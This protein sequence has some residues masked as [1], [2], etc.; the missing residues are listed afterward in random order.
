ML[1]LPDWSTSPLSGWAAAAVA[2]AGHLYRF[3]KGAP[4]MPNVDTILADVDAVLTF[5]V[6]R[7]PGT[8]ADEKKAA[9]N[10]LINPRLTAVLTQEGASPF[11]TGLVV[12][13]VDLAI[14]AEIQL[15]FTPA[16]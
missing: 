16:A 10:N 14:D 1:H 12:D 15:H 6:K 2:T 7:V 9:V 11:L 8:T 13:A 4:L 3:V 5:V